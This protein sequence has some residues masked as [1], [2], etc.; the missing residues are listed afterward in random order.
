VARI[1]I[2]AGITI[3]VTV[4]QILFPFL[5][6]LINQVN[7]MIL[8]PV[9][10]AIYTTGLKVFVLN[11]VCGI[12]SYYI[13]DIRLRSILIFIAAVIALAVIHLNMSDQWIDAL[14]K[15]GGWII[16]VFDFIVLVGAL[17]IS[18]LVPSKV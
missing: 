12:M 10:M 15:P 9:V 3:G 13:N 14:T 17:A 1:F 2:A 6:V 8:I 18:C 16:A 7:G 4:A 5:I 11:T